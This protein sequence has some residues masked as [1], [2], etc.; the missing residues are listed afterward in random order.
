MKNAAFEQIDGLALAAGNHDP[1]C[2]H[3][4]INGGKCSPSQHSTKTKDNDKQ[5]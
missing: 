3:S 4:T 5:A 2:R 1:S